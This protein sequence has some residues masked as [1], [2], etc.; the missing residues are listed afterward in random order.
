MF[1][2]ASCVYVFVYDDVSAYATS[3]VSP[4]SLVP[5]SRLPV[6]AYW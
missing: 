1:P 6:V 5:V 4:V 3:G 2:R